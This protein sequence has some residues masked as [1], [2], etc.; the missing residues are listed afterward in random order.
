[1]YGTRYTVKRLRLTTEQADF[2]RDYAGAKGIN[3]EAAL[4][5][6]GVKGLSGVISALRGNGVEIHSR[7]VRIN[8]RM[9][10]EYALKKKMPPRFWGKC[11]TAHGQNTE[12]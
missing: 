1:M 2:I 6:Y 11:L 5:L 7:L 10:C 12:E 8:G 3:R 4:S 9:C